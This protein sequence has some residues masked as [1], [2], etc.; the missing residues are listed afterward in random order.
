MEAHQLWWVPFIVLLGQWVVAT[1]FHLHYS[2]LGFLC[3]CMALLFSA[4]DRTFSLPISKNKSFHF[5]SFFENSFSEQNLFVNRGRSW[6]NYDSGEV[7]GARVFFIFLHERITFSFPRGLPLHGSMP[8][9]MHRDFPISHKT[10]QLKT[11][12]NKWSD[13]LTDLPWLNFM[14]TNYK[15]HL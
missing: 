11:G 6:T 4:P 2:E 7:I 13:I 10:N 9:W 8:W 14:L 5:R 12:L 1:L 15:L 3:N